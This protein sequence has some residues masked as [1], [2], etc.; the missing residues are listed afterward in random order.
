MAELAQLKGLF[1]QAYQK[2]LQLLSSTVLLTNPPEVRDDNF[3]VR[4]DGAAFFITGHTDAK[5]E[6]TDPKF[7]I[8][9]QAPNFTMW[10]FEHDISRHRQGQQ[11]ERR[12]QQQQDTSMQPKV[13]SSQTMIVNLLNVPHQD[14]FEHILKYKDASPYKCLGIMRDGHKLPLEQLKSYYD[15]LT[16]KFHPDRSDHPQAQNAF[17]TLSNAM[18]SITQQRRRHRAQ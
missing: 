9:A 2:A 6:A 5:L 12:A 17:R 8:V 16:L 15:H 1:A 7:N 4:Y 10:R 11:Q 13:S 14:A 18:Q 3:V